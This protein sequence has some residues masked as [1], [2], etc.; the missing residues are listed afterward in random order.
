[1]IKKL[2]IWK[3][4]EVNTVVIAVIADTAGIEEISAMVNCMGAH[5]AADS[6][7]PG[8][9]LTAKA[10]TSAAANSAKVLKDLELIKYNI[11]FGFEKLAEDG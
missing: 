3:T 7:P 10:F 5:A 4:G 11:R 8:G 1:L 6:A 9:I 2:S